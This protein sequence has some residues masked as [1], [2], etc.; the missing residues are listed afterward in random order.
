MFDGLFVIGGIG[1]VAALVLGYASKIF[2]V[3]EDPLV[4]AIDE[5]LPGANC[6]GCG[7]AGCHSAAEAIAAKKAPPNVCVGGG[8]EVG[9]NV[10]AIMGMEVVALEP[11]LAA[12][13][14][15]GGERALERFSYDGVMDCRAA[16]MLFGGYKVCG[17]G[18]LGFGTCASVCQFGAIEMGPDRLPAF[19]PNLCRGCGAC[20]LACPRGIISLISST[21]KILH[22]NQY[23]ECLAPC[24]QKCPA[25]IDIP[26]YIEHL[27]A[28]RYKEAILTIKERNPLPL[29]CSRVC[30]HPCEDVCR[31]GAVDEAVSINQLKRFAADWEMNQGAHLE[32]P[33]AAPTGHKVAV[34]G[35]GPAGLSCAYYLARLG[36][37]ITIFEKMPELGGMLRYG[38]P[39]YRLPKKTLDWEI[40]G[41]TRLGIDV[42]TNI[43][44]G[45]DITL[46]A[47]K[48]DGFEAVFMGVG[49]WSGRKM[50]VPGEDLDGIWDGIEF[51]AQYHLDGPPEVG[52]QVIVIGGGNTAIDAARTALRLGAKVTLMY[53]RSRDEMP[54]NYVEIVAAE[55]EGIEM[56]FLAAPSRII[57]GNGKAVQI[58]YIKMRLGEPDPSGRRR[59]EPIPDSETIIDGDTIIAAIGQSPAMDNVVSGVGD[60]NFEVT[61]WNTIDGS[62]DTLQTGIP[63]VFTAGD[64]FT[65]PS[66][67]VEAIGGG[68]YAARS[69][70]YFLTENRIPPVEDR[71]TELIRETL[72]DDVKCVEKAS[73][74]HMPEL[75]ISERIT[76][77]EEVDHVVS[78]QEAHREAAR[79]LRCGLIC[80]NRGIVEGHSSDVEKAA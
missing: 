42:K 69:I 45:E 1:F 73:R 80:Y 55:E 3:E 53:R 17:K 61:R 74:V 20:S 62:E 75:K 9:E 56:L 12:I 4:E 23:S 77:F 14:C 28:G 34:I 63:Y 2:Y 48:E 60:E 57:G 31:R 27:K 15:C 11:K 37:A 46:E 25:Q 38:I 10:A 40:E 78:K 59:P 30:P 24:R 36:H 7:F 16:S 41:I 58:E 8:P 13:D 26:T 72:F 21:I 79:C 22:F 65:G 6:G 68:R 49:A 5:A 66:I 18:C 50:G 76:N 44:F 43:G 19:D 32:V 54:A 35:G 52:K 29:A 47:L 64:C 70:H 67:A 71:Q 33:V 39:E 51:L